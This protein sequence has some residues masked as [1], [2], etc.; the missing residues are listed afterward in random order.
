[1]WHCPQGAT[2]SVSH[3][4]SESR[5]YGMGP[6]QMTGPE[7]SRFTKHDLP[8]GQAPEN[9][10]LQFFRVATRGVKIGALGGAF[11]IHLTESQFAG[12]PAN[13]NG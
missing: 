3:C 12:R 9:N 10:S 6:L 11:T 1:M 7:A 4:G 5:W 8:N 13:G 2:C